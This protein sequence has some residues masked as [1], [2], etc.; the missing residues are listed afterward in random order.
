MKHYFVENPVSGKN[1]PIDIIKEK[2]IPAAE[3]AGIDYEVYVTKERGD[4]IRFVREK[5]AEAGDETVRFYAVG[6]D[7]TLYEVV[8]GA[9]GFPNAEVSV[10]PKGSGND[11]IRLYGDR[12]S[13][14]DVPQ[15]INGIPLKVDCLKVEDDDSGWTEVAINQA[16]MGFDAEATAKQSATKKFPGA[17]GHMTYLLAGLYCMFTKVYHTFRCTV[18]G[19][20]I[21]GPFIFAVGCSSRWYG[22][23]I[24]VAP[25]ADPTD[26]KL[27]F[28][29][30]RRLVSWPIIF[31]EGLIDWQT[32]GEHVY[33]P[34]CEYIRGESMELES[35]KPVPI[36]VDGEVRIVKK[37]RFSV[38]PKAI[39]FVI[40][41]DSPYFDQVKSGEISSKID[42]GK[43]H[44]E[45]FH[46]WYNDHLPF[47]V[48]VNK[49]IMGYGRKRK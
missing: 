43:W 36:N 8:N 4:A 17:I 47:N 5:A 25:F 48:I 46:T 28:V 42:Q 40:P 41:A 6:G 34:A 29:I 37:C 1:N 12:E 21:P 31:K 49:W 38:L 15:L 45:P 18:D 23:G 20:E 26:G 7:G 33:K 10:I 30:W 11:Y 24:K 13:F 2:V 27:D 35:K 16:S 39:T 22:S 32:K 9:V 44:K 14:L 19:K 3:E